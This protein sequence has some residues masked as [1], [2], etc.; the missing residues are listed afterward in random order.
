M[1]TDILN[2]NLDIQFFVLFSDLSV[3]VHV[4]YNVSCPT[5]GFFCRGVACNRIHLY[6]NTLGI[7]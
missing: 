5:D 6:S 3:L 2:L 4:T 1:L 7:V